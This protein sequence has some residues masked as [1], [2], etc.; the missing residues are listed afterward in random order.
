[1]YLPTNLTA[2]QTIAIRRVQV[3]KSLD[4]YGRAAA[5]AKIIATD[6]IS[7]RHKDV[8][9]EAKRL[10]KIAFPGATF[11]ATSKAGCG[12]SVE[13]VDGPAFAKVQRALRKL[14]HQNNDSDGQADCYQNWTIVRVDGV[15]ITHG[16]M[17]IR[18]IVSRATAEAATKFLLD[19]YG[20]EKI[21][22]SCGHW[23]RELGQVSLYVGH[24][25]LHYVTPSPEMVRAVHCAGIPL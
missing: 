4:L 7:I 17:S 3:N 12:I 1:M 2:H 20:A 19:V 25:G 18:R 6:S 21:S 5:I 24:S 23:P 22:A 10:L 15:A 14:N 9:T 8:A 11:S 16:L 13:W